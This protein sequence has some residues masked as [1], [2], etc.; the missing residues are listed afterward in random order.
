MGCAI[1]SYSRL[2]PP[3]QW[4]GAILGFDSAEPN[5]T[6]L[7]GAIHSM[8]SKMVS[9]KDCIG[10]MIGIEQTEVIT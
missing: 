4:T 5:C 8:V 1:Y 7:V 10:E 9:S 6:N 2:D 3:S